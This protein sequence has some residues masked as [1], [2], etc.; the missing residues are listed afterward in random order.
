MNDDI[1]RL[2][3]IIALS[4]CVLLIAMGF[5]ALVIIAEINKKK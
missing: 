2:A 3:V 5:I 1:Q 4:D